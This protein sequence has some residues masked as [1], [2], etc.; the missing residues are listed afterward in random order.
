MTIDEI[1]TLLKSGDVVGAEAAAQELLAAEQDNV[2]A[3]ILYGTCRQLQGDEATF[4]DAY[5]MVKAALDANEVELD[6]VTAEE[7]KRFEMLHR[8][9]DQPELLRKGDQPHGV[10][11]MEYV[12]LTLLIA[13]AVGVVVWW[14]G[15]EIAEILSLYAGSPADV[16]QLYAGPVRNEPNAPYKAATDHPEKFTEKFTIEA[17][18]K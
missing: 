16:R 8:N 2:R 3:M 17:D 13:A 11:N 14:Y 6:M 10:L 4:R 5:D 1:K 9:L 15:K 7:W 12:V 18:V